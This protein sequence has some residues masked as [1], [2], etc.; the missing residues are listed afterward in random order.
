MDREWRVA[1][2]IQANARGS[3]RSAEN[4]GA[5]GTGLRSTPLCCTRTF[6]ISL[7]VAYRDRTPQLW[8]VFPVDV[9][10]FGEIIHKCI[11]HTILVALRAGLPARLV[12]VPQSRPARP[13]DAG[14]AAIRL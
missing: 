10:I 7:I 8:R 6:P 5:E 9:V 12:N 13:K 3:G 11:K 14:K 2:A 1:P 4:D